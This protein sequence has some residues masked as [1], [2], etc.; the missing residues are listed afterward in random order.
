[1]QPTG[2]IFATE[3]KLSPTIWTPNSDDMY[4]TVYSVFLASQDALEVMYVSDSV[5]QSAE[6]DFTDVTLVSDDTNCFT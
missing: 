4:C 6:K 1:M 3:K 5:S 2:I